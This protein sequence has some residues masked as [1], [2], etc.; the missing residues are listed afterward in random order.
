MKTKKNKPLLSIPVFDDHLLSG[1][2][3]YLN[4]MQLSE[5]K[6]PKI[7]LSIKDCFEHFQLSINK[8]KNCKTF[9]E[10]LDLLQKDIS[11]E[12]GQ[13]NGRIVINL[14][15]KIISQTTEIIIE[16]LKEN[17]LPIKMNYPFDIIEEEIGIKTIHI[18]E[19]WVWDLII[20]ESIETLINLNPLELFHYKDSFIYS[21]QINTPEFNQ[22]YEEDE[23][24]Y[25]VL[26]DEK[27][28]Y[29]EIK[30]NDL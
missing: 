11:I 6:K 5:A 15:K 19:N 16:F 14:F 17:S 30:K 1:G 8:L 24:H 27:K 3:V 29:W 28:D 22:D 2:L 26:S 9:Y 20:E 13:N 23:P 4:W 7:T 18:N 25:I 10:K 12:Y 21:A